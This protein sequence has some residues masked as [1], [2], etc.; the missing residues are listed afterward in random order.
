[1]T[2]EFKPYVGRVFELRNYTNL[3]KYPPAVLIFD[4]TAKDV[5]FLDLEQNPVWISKSYLRPNPLDCKHFATPDTLT[6]VMSLIESMRTMLAEG[7]LALD[8]K[9]LAS[10]NKKCERALSEL[11]DIATRMSG[12]E[13]ASSSEEEDEKQSSDSY[14]LSQS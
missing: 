4:E 14:T 12:V 9:K 7:E 6:T 3:K 8:K 2:K 1:M 5:M 11:R 10:L 13:F